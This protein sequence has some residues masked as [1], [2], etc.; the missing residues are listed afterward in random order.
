MKPNFLK[1]GSAFCLFVLLISLNLAHSANQKPAIKLVSGADIQQRVQVIKDKQNLADELKSRI[2]AAYYESEDNL[3]ELD[4]QEAQAESFK[5]ALN[6]LPLEAK[7]LARQIAEAENNLKNRKA[8]KLAIFPTDELEQR[9]ITEK[10]RLSD[11]DAE[12]SRIEVQIGDLSNRPQLIREKVS[13]IKSKQAS[14]QQEQQS[15]ASRAGDN[16]YQKEAKQIQL[17]TRIRLLN[18]TLKTLELENISNPLRL[19]AHKDRIHLLTLQR[20]QQSLLIADLD[21]FLLDRK[22]Q[23]IDKEQIELLQAEKE[24]EGKHPLIRQVTKENSQ[25]NRSLQEINKNTEQYLLQ[26]NEIDVRYKQLEKDFQSAEQK[27]TLAGLS[28]ALGNLLREQRRNIPQRKTY[29]GLNEEI[30][31]QIALASLEMFKLDEAKKNL[32]DIN[33]VLLKRVAQL[34]AETDEAEKLRIRTE[35]RMLLND[36]KDLVTR[37]AG[38]YNEY[39]RILGDVDFSL[40]QMLT[41]ADKFSAYLNQRLLW[42][43]SAPVIGKYYLKDIFSSLLWLMSP[44]NWLGVAT[45]FWDSLSHFPLLVLVGLGIVVLHWRF[46]TR[47]KL[48][49][50][51]LL[52]KKA[53]S[54]DFGDIVASLLYLLLMSLY[55]AL[56]MAWIG[57]VLILNSRADFFSHSFAEGL[58]AAAVS[59]CMIQFFYRLFKPDGVADTLFHWPDHAIALLYSQMKWARFILVPAVFIISM[60]ASDLFSEHSY[61]LGRTALIVMMATLAYVFHRLTQPQSGLGKNFYL[62]STGWISRLRYVWYAIAVLTPVVIIGFAVTGY[63]QSAL[64][65]QGKLVL[66]LRLLFLTVLFQGLVLRWLR[67]TERKLALKNARQK[68]KQVEQA[69]VASASI[70]GSYPLEEELLDISKINQQSHKLLTTMVM[71]SLLVGCWMIWSDILPALTVFDQVVLWQHSQVVDGKDILQPITLINLLACLVYSGL[72]FVFASNF[73]ALVDLITVGKFEM[74]A[75]SRYALI[76]LVRYSLVTVAFLAVANEMGGSWSQVQ[77]LVA[78]LSVG[79]GFGLQEIFANMVSGII[80]LFER[81]IRVGDTVTVGDVTGRVSRIQ[82]RATHIVDWDRK[83]LVVPNKI[84]ITDRLINWTLSDTVTR[85]VVPVS[86]AY[87]TNV[88]MVEQILTDAVKSI[89]EVLCD[90]EPVVTFVGFGDSALQFKIHVFVRELSDRAVVTHRL[91]TQIY[92]ALLAH[93]IEIPYP[94]RDVHI[95]SVAKEILNE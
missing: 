43:P 20:E 73:P 19:Q 28:P 13:E 29:N 49:L 68:R 63:Y 46:K 47:I 85:V 77:W 8:E 72:A 1:S 25:Y 39:G 35:L 76:Q 78:A 62:Q 95:R 38:G 84:F 52:N 59:L 27:I 74:T 65:L 71:V 40:Q 10:T 50:A 17:E 69:A 64:E 60:T 75:G 44:S 6:D 83:E 66:T 93:H 16:L 58:I 53:I 91:H 9:L 87:G 79:L 36:Q 7:Q 34:P 22:Q 67:N 11:L 33:Q 54:H 3:S 31:S 5:L 4:A 82:M 89:A 70:E 45:G 86:V 18:S 48:Q 92:E 26:K 56:L 57:G 14:S 23:E 32:S 80:L 21:N 12:I 24:A 30:Q 41:I 81:P 2:L 88:E 94:Q 15:L 42:V 51:M 37:L 61:A 90:P 55:G